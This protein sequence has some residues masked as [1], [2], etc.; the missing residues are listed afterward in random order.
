[1]K[2]FK[3]IICHKSMTKKLENFEDR[4]YRKTT[5]KR[6][7]DTRQFYF[8]IHEHDI[9]TSFVYSIYHDGTNLDHFKKKMRKVISD[10]SVYVGI[11]CSVSFEYVTTLST[12]FIYIVHDGIR[13]K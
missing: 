8:D 2:E 6:I 13:Y 9:G 7:S 10:Y 5:S 4:N 3:H 12:I 1:M 11:Y